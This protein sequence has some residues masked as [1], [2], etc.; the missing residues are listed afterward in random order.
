MW[1]SVGAQ[2]IGQVVPSRPGSLKFVGE[3]VRVHNMGIS[4]LL[5][6]NV[7]ALLVPQKNVER[8][9]QWLNVPVHR[10]CGERRSP[11]VQPSTRPEIEPGTFLLVN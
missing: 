4:L 8:L 9:E 7:W 2:A 1:H 3:E 5:S 6:T 10:W 11:K